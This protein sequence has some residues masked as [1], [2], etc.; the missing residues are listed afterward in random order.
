ML[1]TKFKNMDNRTGEKTNNQFSEDRGNMEIVPSEAK[2]LVPMDNDGLDIDAG[3]G[4]RIII[5]RLNVFA[6]PFRKRHEKYYK[7][8]RL[9]LWADV[10]VSLVIVA[11]LGFLVAVKFWHPSK[12]IFI[13]S[14]L[15]N[16]KVIAGKTETFEIFYGNKNNE[17][18]EDSN[19][20]VILPD[21][22][23]LESVEPDKLFDLHSNTFRIG[24]LPVGANGRL[25]IKGV[26]VGEVGSRKAMYF[27]FNFK[28]NIHSL[29][30]LNSLHYTISGSSLETR[31]SMPD[32][33]FQAIPFNGKINIKNNGEKDLDKVELVVAGDG[34]AIKQGETAVN[35]NILTVKGLK[36][37]EIKA[38]DFQAIVDGRTGKTNFVVTSF[39]FAGKNRFKQQEIIKNIEIKAPE[40]K[41]LIDVD[42]KN[43]FEN[44][45]VVFHLKYENNGQDKLK[46]IK[47]SLYATDENFLLGDIL[48]SGGSQFKKNSNILFLDEII[49]GDKKI[50][51]IKVKFNRRKISFNNQAALAADV[52]YETDDGIVLYSVTSEP[53]KIMS[54]L[55]VS[56]A[57][58]YYS[59]QGDQ[60]GVGPLPPTVGIPTRYW[61]FWEANNIGNDLK[62]FSLA[63]ELPADVIWTNKKSLPAGSLEY[64]QIG[65]RVIWTVDEISKNGGNYKAGFEVEII[66]KKTDLGKTLTLLTDIKYSVFDIFCNQA[67]DGDLEG[68]NTNLKSDKL[69]VGKGQVT[70]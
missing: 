32:N 39:V 33:I 52:S 9:H 6:E 67:M 56:S 1:N 7:D 62:N 43:M 66:P 64:G 63:A 46:N 13:E 37:G 38:I 22:F 40:F 4:G 16:D 69:V 58:Y 15:E 54:D 59:P 3:N 29:S 61:I 55:K 68:I 47:L 5:G 51:D 70:E 34:L 50:I 41:V 11:L 10:I 24:N 31:I 65:R 36:A 20:A 8:S 57:G 49:S 48:L 2:P 18:I 23:I 35:D 17:E 21:N 27:T 14:S 60:L 45:E 44:E 42:Q 25:K 30:V 19:I 28:K 26:Q 12:N 53:I